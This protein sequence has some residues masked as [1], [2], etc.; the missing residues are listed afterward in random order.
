LSRKAVHNSVDKFSQGHS[1]VAD[2]ARLDCLIEIATKATV[3]R[4][5][6]LIRA[7][8]RITIDS[9]ATALGHSHGFACEYSIMHDHLKF[10]KLGTVGAQRTERSRINLLNVSILAASLTLCR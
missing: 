6:Q 7:D 2:D 10:R 1:K 3:Q 8:R 9:V 5:E 4:V